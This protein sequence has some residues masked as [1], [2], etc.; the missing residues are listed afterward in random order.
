MGY[1]YNKCISEIREFDKTVAEAELF[2]IGESVMEKKIYCLG[3]GDG[4]KKLFVN[5]AHHGLEYIT[6]AFLMRFM[7]EF[8]GAVESG[9]DMFG[10][11]VGKL[12]KGIRLFVVPMV[13]PDGVDIAVNGLDITNRYHRRLISMV[14][15][16]S[17][18]KVWQANANGVDINHNY[19]ARWSVVEKSPAPSKYSGPYAE[20]EPETKAVC[21]FVRSMDFDM[22]MAF[23][24]QGGEIYYDFDGLAAKADKEAAERMSRASGYPVRTPAGSAS[25]GGCKDWFIKEFGRSGFTV[26]MGHGK[27]PLPEERL[28]EFYEENAK[29]ILS[30]MQELVC[31]E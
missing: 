31:L 7:R 24:S 11:D 20:S 23:H 13:N 30:A 12:K 29:I 1:D 15:I 3:Y 18:N 22:L 28:C 2:S 14:G 8:A 5:G 17:F 27:N 25:F 21:E 9:A 19:D 10:Y 26:E 6:S 16:H 4:D